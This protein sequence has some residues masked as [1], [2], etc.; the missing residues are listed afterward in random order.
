MIK[1]KSVIGI[2]TAAAA[3][4]TAVGCNDKKDSDISL[5]ET[6]IKAE[7]DLGEVPTYTSPQKT[8]AASSD[9]TD[10]PLQTE[11]A[12]A[13]AAEINTAVTQASSIQTSPSNIDSNISENTESQVTEEALPVHTE[14]ARTEPE[15]TEPGE[16]VFGA[17]G[18]TEDEWLMLAQ[19]MYMQ[20][21]EISFRYR[22]TGSEFPIDRANLDIIDKT[23]FL[24]T[25]PSFEEAT[26]GYYEIFSHAYHD[27]DF[28]GLL[29]VQDGRVYAARSSRGMDMTYLSSAVKGIVSVSET[30]AVF[31]V[32]VQYESEDVITYFSLVP[33]DGVTKVG[34]FEL[35]Y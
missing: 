24:T 22:F 9:K 29:L 26:K 5:V 15:P 21:C 30:E 6:N 1:L 28:E 18:R 23:Y 16:G 17:E 4:L 10:I 7:T 31:E 34:E 32:L 3:F 2:F 25:C 33:E 19:E 20:A 12:T 27:G 13:T 14:P 35:P 11:A 8:E